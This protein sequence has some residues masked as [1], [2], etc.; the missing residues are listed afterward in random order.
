[1]KRTAHGQFLVM[2]MLCIVVARVAHTGQALAQG[3]E[4]VGLVVKFGDGSVFT[5][6]ID[7]TGPGMTGEDV[8]DGSGLSTVKEIYPGLGAA[9]CKI[10]NDGCDYP[11]PDSCFCECTGE[12]P[13]QYWA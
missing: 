10:G 8:L 9:I 6:C 5:D 2:G 4:Q 7:Y 11:E 3:A 12:P 13:C 1:M